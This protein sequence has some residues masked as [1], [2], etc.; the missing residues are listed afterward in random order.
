MPGR[1]KPMILLRKARIPVDAKPPLEP[2][3]CKRARRVPVRDREET[4][5]MLIRCI[6]QIARRPSAAAVQASCL[7]PVQR[8]QASGRGEL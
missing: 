3:C 8:A 6:T 7:V 2:F 1:T 4:R 5:P